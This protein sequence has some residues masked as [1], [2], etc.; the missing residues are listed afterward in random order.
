MAS[1]SLPRSLKPSFLDRL[2]DVSTD[3]SRSAAWYDL[4]GIVAAVKRDLDNLLNTRQSH[5]GACDGFEE[6]QRSL[7]TYGLPDAA[8]MAVDT[9][10][11]RLQLARRIEAII[12]QFEPR[13][14]QVHVR[15]VDAPDNLRRVLQFQI[16]G[17][18][19]IEPAVDLQLDASMELTTGQLTLTTA[20]T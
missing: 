6:V 13:L 12:A 19:Q 3:D 20:K 16:L 5:Q 17:R 1:P 11:Q 18:L 15:I 4:D 14:R 10:Q 2:I 9:P 7:I 8:S